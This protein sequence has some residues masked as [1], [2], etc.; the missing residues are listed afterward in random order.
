[1]NVLSALSRPKLPVIAAAL[2]FSLSAPAVVAQNPSPTWAQDDTLRIAKEVQK[3]LASLP[4][5][6]VFDWITFGFHGKT[7][8]IPRPA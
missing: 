4:N 3:R 7:A 1:M 8:S 2:I 6:G 5:L